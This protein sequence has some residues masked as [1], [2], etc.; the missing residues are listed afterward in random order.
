MVKGRYD[1]QPISK[2]EMAQINKHKDFGDIMPYVFNS[3]VSIYNDRP[4]KAKPNK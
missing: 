4:I 1:I 3:G 2:K